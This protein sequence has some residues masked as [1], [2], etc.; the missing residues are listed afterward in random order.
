MFSA[1]W[2][3]WRRRLAVVG[4][5]LVVLGA[6]GAGVYL[7][8]DSLSGGEEGG[9]AP[10]PKVVIHEEHPEAA[11]DLGFPEFA[12]KNTTRV[13]GAD[14]IAAAAGVAL[15]VFPSTGGVEGPAAVTLVDGADWPSGIA[16]ASL[17]APPVQA[18]ILITDADST[19][20]LTADALRA[21]GPSGSAITGDHQIFAIGSAAAPSGARTE[22]VSGGNPA[23]LAAAVDKLREDLS[24][25]PPQ[26][27]LLDELRQATVRD[28][29]GRLGGPFRRPRSVRGEG[30]GPQAHARSPSP[31]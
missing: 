31:T 5:A 27:I 29:R 25:D 7:L 18:P 12:T 11:Q 15:S 3:D 9:P 23:E 28:A 16:A 20:S 21:L 8:V 26:H 4:G 6:L 24:G 22:R 13:A 14:P 1:V 30:V 2:L 19:P 17:M 10:A